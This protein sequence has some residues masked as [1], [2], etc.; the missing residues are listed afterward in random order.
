VVSAGVAAAGAA[1]AVVAVAVGRILAASPF[2]VVGGRTVAVGTLVAAVAG[3]P[4]VLEGSQAVSEETPVA[5][6]D[7]L[8]V[9]VDI[10]VGRWEGSLAVAADILAVAPEIVGVVRAAVEAK[11]LAEIPVAEVALLLA[12]PLTPVDT[13]EVAAPATESP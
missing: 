10:P 9:E 11:I 7:T 13:L 4:A 2:V 8:E 12:P 1:A 5:Q 6:E 3:T